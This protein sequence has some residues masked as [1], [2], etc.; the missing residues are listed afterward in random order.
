[1]PGMER[2]RAAASSRPIAEPEALHTSSPSSP[3]SAGKSISTLD[4]PLSAGSSGSAQSCSSITASPSTT[5]DARICPPAPSVAITSATT[6]RRRLGPSTTLASMPATTPAADV[7]V[8]NSC[9]TAPSSRGPSS[10]LISSRAT[11]ASDAAVRLATDAVLASLTPLM[12]LLASDAASSFGATGAAAAFRGPS[13]GGPRDPSFTGAPPSVRGAPK[14]R[15]VGARGAFGGVARGL[16]PAIRHDPPPTSG[17]RAFCGACRHRPTLGASLRAGVVERAGVKCAAP[18]PPAA[19]F[20]AVSAASAA[21]FRC[22]STCATGAATL[23]A[24]A[25]ADATPPTRCC[26]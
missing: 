7:A 9:L 18:W 10:I 2:R 4:Q 20:S 19:S 23:G 11:A 6:A 13:A 12:T 25:W 26:L 21:N 5:S 16:L 24:G 15:A 3:G 22:D 8:P 17:I 14:R 1:M